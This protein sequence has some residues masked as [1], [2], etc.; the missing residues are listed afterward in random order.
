M[1]SPFERSVEGAISNGVEYLLRL[2]DADGFWRE[3][4]LQPGP[5]DCWAT[6]WVGWCLTQSL[7]PEGGLRLRVR[8]SLRRATGA[9]LRSKGVRGWGY[10]RRTGPDADTTAWVLRFLRDCGVRVDVAPLLAP[11]IDAGGG[12][13]TFRELDFGAWTDAHDDVAANVGLALLGAAVTTPMAERIRRRLT[14]RFP[15][16]TFWWST[17]AY[18]IAWTLRFLSRTGGLSAGFRTRSRAWFAA[19]PASPSSFEIAH[20]LIGT[21]EVAGDE[22][23]A[24]VDVNQLLDLAGPEGWPGSSLLLVPPREAGLQTPPNPELRGLLTTAIC[25]R[26]L[27]EWSVSERLRRSPS[28]ALPSASQIL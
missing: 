28:A 25:A 11:Y 1:R 16:E 12:V 14:R 19:M 20:R 21:A 24:L 18:G 7:V 22:C 5:S 3:F 9:L 23:D 17:P 10:N 2:Q 4:D 6:A 27:S 13:H 26:A 15:V 8:E